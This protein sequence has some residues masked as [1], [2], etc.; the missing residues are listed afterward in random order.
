MEIS[1]QHISTT[2]QPFSNLK[3]TGIDFNIQNE[4]AVVNEM[5]KIKDTAEFIGKLDHEI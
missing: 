1:S 2:I 4:L 5:F 3:T